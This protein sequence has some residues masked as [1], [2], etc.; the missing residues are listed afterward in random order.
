MTQGK[1]AHDDTKEE[2]RLVGRL[3]RLA[4]PLARV[5]AVSVSVRPCPAV[6]ALV[7]FGL[8]E[9]MPPRLGPESRLPTPYSLLHQK[10]LHPPSSI[11]DQPHR[12][13][14]GFHHRQPGNPPR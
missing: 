7:V 13:S 11:R 5:R 2:S 14:R 8:S 1:H 6:E 12:S 4:E 9:L 10:P 3:T